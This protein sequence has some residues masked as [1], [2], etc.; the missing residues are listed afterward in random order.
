M[1]DKLFRGARESVDELAADVMN[2]EGHRL[3]QAGAPLRDWV[4]RAELGELGQFA[5]DELVMPA[6]VPHLFGQV[7]DHG[8]ITAYRRRYSP[9]P[10]STEHDTDDL[11]TAR[12]GTDMPFA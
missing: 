7:L 1:F 12:S 8:A 6:D 9:R 3:S 4:E 5:F 2:I 10:G 11:D